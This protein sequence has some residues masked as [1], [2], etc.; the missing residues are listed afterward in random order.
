MQQN[1]C[2]NPREI[3]LL[4]WS[5][6][7][8]PLYIL[9]VVIVKLATGCVTI[10][11]DDPDIIVV[12]EPDDPEQPEPQPEPTEPDL[13]PPDPQPEPEPWCGME[14]DITETDTPAFGEDWTNGHPFEVGG[15]V[16]AIDIVSAPDFVYVVL[17]YYDES[18]L[19][20]QYWVVG[21]QLGVSYV[22]CEFWVQD[23]ATDTARAHIL[24][25]RICWS[26]GGTVNHRATTLSTI[27]VE[28]GLNGI[29]HL[30]ELEQEQGCRNYQIAA[31]GA[32]LVLGT[33]NCQTGGLSVRP[34]HRMSGNIWV[35][36]E[37]I[38]VEYNYPWAFQR[39]IAFNAT[40]GLLTYELAGQ[41]DVQTTRY[42][43]CE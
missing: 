41:R 13:A 30:W 19:R 24:V 32:E 4:T 31:D 16:G 23:V 40:D 39:F 35:G 12:N 22:G 37:N 21:Q 1:D 5:L 28:E 33:Y 34:L 42:R 7:G 36:E 10:E 18:N 43:A 14:T 20:R 25:S 11:G 2:F 38:L 8:T 26:E 9:M 15:G 27:D 3:K 6:R 29:W 17:N